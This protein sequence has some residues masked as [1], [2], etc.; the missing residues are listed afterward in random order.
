MIE[1]AKR[2]R[3]GRAYHSVLAPHLDF[4]RQLRRERKTWRE[5]A[6][7]LQRAH[8]IRVTLYAP[9]LFY[10]RHLRRKV[11]WED[12]L[13]VQ[14]PVAPAAKPAPVPLPPPSHFRRPDRDQFKP[15]DYL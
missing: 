2:Q 10:K 1:T 8:G 14:S 15:D 13:L 6:E 3:G 7:A 5:V 11:R 12:Q 9:Y 4:I